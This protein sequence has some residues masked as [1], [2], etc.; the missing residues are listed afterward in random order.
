MMADRSDGEI[1]D[2]AAYYAIQK[3][4]SAGGQTIQPEELAATCE[5]CHGPSVGTRKM[6]VPSLK[7]QNRDYLVR[8]MKAYRGD[9]RGSSMM[10]KM[11]ASYSDEM[12]EAIA[13]YYASHP[14]D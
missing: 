3:A 7:G 13:T 12:I 11:S 1:E 14:A 6:I 5:R 10:H 8:V 2:I 4:E 9:D